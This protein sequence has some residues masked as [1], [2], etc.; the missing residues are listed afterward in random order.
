[1]K[2]DAFWEVMPEIDQLSMQ[3]YYI[4]WC[5]VYPNRTIIS[6]KLNWDCKSIREIFAHKNLICQGCNGNQLLQANC[7]NTIFMLGL[8]KK[9]RYHKKDADV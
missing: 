8:Y 1:M 5:G 6:Y 9:D 4:L 2:V 3:Y 7:C